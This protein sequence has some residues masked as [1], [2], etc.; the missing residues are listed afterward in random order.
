MVTPAAT[1]HHVEAILLARRDRIRART[2]LALTVAERVADRLLLAGASRVVLFGSL[3]KGTF[4]EHSDIDLAVDGMSPKAR[5]ALA[6]E[7]EALAAP[8]LLDVV[9]MERLPET[10]LA[11]LGRVARVLRE[12]VT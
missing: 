9:P 8:F 5:D 3:A 1:R 2:A 11:T 6:E 4:G 12:R 7:L 10:T